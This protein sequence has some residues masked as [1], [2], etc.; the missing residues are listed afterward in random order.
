VNWRVLTPLG[1]IAL[2]AVLAAIAI[3]AVFGF[4]PRQELLP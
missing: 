2:S 1:W 3:G 4:E